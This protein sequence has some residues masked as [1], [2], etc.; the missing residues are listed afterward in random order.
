MN[1]HDDSVQHN[2]CLTEGNPHPIHPRILISEAAQSGLCGCS[3]SC[4]RLFQLYDIL[5]IISVCGAGCVGVQHLV[6]EFVPEALGKDS[7]IRMMLYD[8]WPLELTEDAYAQRSRRVEE[9]IE[10][11]QTKHKHIEDNTSI[12]GNQTKFARSQGRKIQI[13]VGQEYSR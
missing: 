3:T 13:T 12:D 10:L 2:L 8:H 9:Q 1:L 11:L 5:S 7:S 6:A 4:S